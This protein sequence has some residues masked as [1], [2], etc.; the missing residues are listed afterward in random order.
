[1]SERHSWTPEPLWLK[2]GQAFPFDLCFDFG[3]SRILFLRAG[4]LSSRSSGHFGMLTGRGRAREQYEL[5]EA[6]TLEERVKADKGGIIIPFDAVSRVALKKFWGRPPFLLIEVNL[7]ADGVPSPEETRYVRKHE[8]D[9]SSK[10]EL[11]A[12][13]VRQIRQA[14]PGSALGP[15]F[16]DGAK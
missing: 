7:D 5:V 8:F 3:N 4:S 1:M 10:R 9:L 12:E 15:R 6:L 2:N 13:Q 14:V 11:Q 16:E